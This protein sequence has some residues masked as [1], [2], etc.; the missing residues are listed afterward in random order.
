MS[1]KFLTVNEFRYY[2]QFII[3]IMAAIQTDSDV[4]NDD[5][6]INVMKEAY[7]Q[8]HSRGYATRVRLMS[9]KQ[10]REYTVSCWK[11]GRV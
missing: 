2:T 7:R 11:I 4:L 8:I 5:E 3:V 6:T 10:R 9:G 1:G